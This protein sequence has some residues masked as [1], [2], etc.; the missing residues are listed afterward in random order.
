MYRHL[1]TDLTAPARPA[2]R[3]NVWTSRNSPT[4]RLQHS[5]SYPP[6]ITLTALT[7]HPSTPIPP[8]KLAAARTLNYIPFFFA[9]RPLTPT[10]ASETTYGFPATSP[11]TPRPAT[12][13]IVKVPA[14]RKFEYEA[15]VNWCFYSEYTTGFYTKKCLRTAIRLRVSYELAAACDYAL[16]RGLPSLSACFGST[17]VELPTDTMCRRPASDHSLLSALQIAKISA[18]RYPHQLPP[19]AQLPTPDTECR[20]PASAPFTTPG[21]H[22]VPPLALFKSSKSHCAGLNLIAFPGHRPF[23]LSSRC[24]AL[25]LKAWKLSLDY[26]T[27]RATVSSPRHLNERETGLA[28]PEIAFFPRDQHA[29]FSSR[30]REPRAR[31]TRWVFLPHK[32]TPDSVGVKIGTEF[33]PRAGE[34][35][36]GGSVRKYWDWRDLEMALNAEWE[37]LE[38]NCLK[39]QSFQ[40]YSKPRSEPPGR[41]LSDA[42]RLTVIDWQ[43]LAR[44]A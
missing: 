6:A 34:V 4:P 40:A 5:Y 41:G 42:K 22:Q 10:P 20:T 1:V 23:N 3:I 30:E 2:L 18:A 26:K 25:E 15:E 7:I 12:S 28:N 17:A 16:M 38:W 37:D 11:R 31:W 39:N 27:T 8:L 35:Q 14:A 43:V 33:E 29:L 24:V 36:L 9:G 13:K 21:A 44:V 32:E 19:S